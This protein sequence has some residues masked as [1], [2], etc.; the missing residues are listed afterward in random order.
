MHT[1]APAEGG[2]GGG[3]RGGKSKNRTDARTTD[4]RCVFHADSSGG[5]KGLVRVVRGA[6]GV[7][8]LSAANQ[9]EVDEEKEEGGGGGGGRGDDGKVKKGE[10]GM[11]SFNKAG[12]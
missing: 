8:R 6:S 3:G 9:R 12:G 10:A 2:G 11:A 1:Y 7:G 5:D 4:L